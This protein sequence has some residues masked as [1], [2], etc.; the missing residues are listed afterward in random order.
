[1]LVMMF[2]VSND[3]LKRSNKI[4]SPAAVLVTAKE[5]SGETGRKQKNRGK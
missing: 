2:E 3:R 5:D 1:M 4:N